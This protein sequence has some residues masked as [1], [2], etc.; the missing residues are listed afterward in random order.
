M[1]YVRN[2]YVPQVVRVAEGEAE[3]A[4]GVYVAAQFAGPE[5]QR[6]FLKMNEFGI[7]QTPSLKE[8]EKITF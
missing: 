1:T 8:F 2:F 4:E 7:R 6:V 3:G 5:N